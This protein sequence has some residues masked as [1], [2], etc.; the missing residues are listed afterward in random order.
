[1]GERSIAVLTNGTNLADIRDRSNLQAFAPWLFDSKGRKVTPS[2]ET[3]RVEQGIPAENNARKFTKKRDGLDVLLVPLETLV[4]S[5]A[6][7]GK[8]KAPDR[9][10]TQR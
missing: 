5:V 7:N 8:G 4:D 2:L 6:E 10:G 9:S 1:M 3:Q